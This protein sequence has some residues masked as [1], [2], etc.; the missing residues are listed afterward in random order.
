MRGRRTLAVILAAGALALF[1]CAGKPIPEPREASPSDLATLRRTAGLPE[2]PNT[3][4]AAASVP[5]G[6]PQTALACLGGGP[7]V[8]LAGLPRHKMVINLW[9]QW[10]GPCREESP[11]LAEAKSRLEGKVQFFGIN[12]TDP[13]EDL[14]IE[15]AGLVGWTYPHVADPERTLR[16]ALGV[17]GLPLTLFVDSEGRVV[18][19]HVG[20]IVSTEELMELV[21]QHLGE[22]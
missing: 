2:C 22:S 3:D 4:A 5:E 12:Y 14:A 16:A 8:N 10:C 17:T 19:R 15:F 1:G 7:K 6:L 21:A 20:V 9:A 18:A 11:Y 13:R